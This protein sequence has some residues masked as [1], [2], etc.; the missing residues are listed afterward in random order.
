MKKIQIIIA[1]LAVSADAFAVSP[2]DSLMAMGSI[3]LHVANG[4]LLLDENRLYDAGIAYQ[5][6]LK[7]AEDVFGLQSDVLIIPLGKL[8][9]V[10]DEQGRTQ[11]ALSKV[12]RVISII[13]E[14]YPNQK[15]LIQSWKNAEARLMNR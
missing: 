4:D 7:E 13:E 3:K 12:R 5:N 10:L 2:C 15:D 8:A 14:L 9:V 1:L 11:E 6:A